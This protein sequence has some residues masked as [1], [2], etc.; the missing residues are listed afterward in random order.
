[1]NLL[2]KWMLI[3]ISEFRS[4]KVF[5]NLTQVF[6]NCLILWFPKIFCVLSMWVFIFSQIYLDRPYRRL[7]QPQPLPQQ[8]QRHQC[9]QRPCLIHLEKAKV[10]VF[11]I[12]NQRHFQLRIICLISSHANS[13]LAI[14]T[15]HW[16]SLSTTKCL[17][18]P[19][20]WIAIRIY[21]VVIKLLA[22]RVNT[23]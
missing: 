21:L 8:P 10:G 19:F 11:L 12:K 3:K 4:L 1:M 14:H 2:W 5:S 23:F 15:C 18:F 16:L 20:Q 9:H 22:N 17:H 13:I 7:W 6:K